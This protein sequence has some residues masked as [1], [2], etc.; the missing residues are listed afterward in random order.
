[1]KTGRCGLSQSFCNF[2]LHNFAFVAEFC[3]RMSNFQEKQTFRFI[4]FY[5]QTHP[6]DNNA[7]LSKF[8]TETSST[9]PSHCHQF[10]TEHG[11]KMRGTHS[12][13][14]TEMPNCKWNGT[15]ETPRERREG[16]GCTIRISSSGTICFRLAKSAQI[17]RDHIYSAPPPRNA[18]GT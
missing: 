9:F 4:L 2:F 15:A 5:F 10:L 3:K 14:P 13:S 6:W 17:S 7:S 16:W 1:M 12:S 18:V 11:T 8:C